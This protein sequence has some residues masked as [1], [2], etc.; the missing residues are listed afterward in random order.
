[1]LDGAASAVEELQR[2][3]RVPEPGDERGAS[4]HSRSE[5]G[6]RSPR[7]ARSRTRGTLDGSRGAAP[8]SRPGRSRTRG[9]VAGTGHGRRGRR[10]TTARSRLAS[11]R[12]SCARRQAVVRSASRA[13]PRRRDRRARRRAPATTSSRSSARSRWRT[14]C[15]SRTLRG[16]ARA[17]GQSLVVAGGTSVTRRLRRRRR[18]RAGLGPSLLVVANDRELDHPHCRQTRSRLRKPT[19][20]EGFAD[21][22]VAVDLGP[23]RRRR[24]SRSGA[25]TATAPRSTRPTS[26]GGA[27]AAHVR[28]GR[29]DGDHDMPT[30]KDALDDDGGGV[31]ADAL[32]P[33]RGVDAATGSERRTGAADD[34]P[35]AHRCSM[36]DPSIDEGSSRVVEAKM[37]VTLSA[38]SGRTVTVAVATREPGPPPSPGDDFRTGAGPRSRS[39]PAGR[40]RR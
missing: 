11:R 33:R 2:P 7:P 27:G 13:R 22:G 4:A 35:H 3:G 30:V 34:D 14:S 15:S 24:R 16:F 26:T 17:L 29:D 19:A 20:D 21:D 32:V 40:R 23:G 37:A 25:P 28:G 9:L 8:S 10:R 6:G 1:M 38:A 31:H 5:A 36:A 12:G 39:L 18:R